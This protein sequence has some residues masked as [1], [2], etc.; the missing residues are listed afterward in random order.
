MS[1]LVER[2]WARRHPETQRV[3]PEG[4]PGPTRCSVRARV[5]RRIVWLE[6][7]FRVMRP[8]D[9]GLADRHSRAVRVCPAVRDHRAGRAGCSGSGPP[10]SSPSRACP[11]LEGCA[12]VVVVARA[13]RRQTVDGDREWHEAAARVCRAAGMPPLAV[14]VATPHE[15]WRLDDLAGP[16][17]RSASSRR[18]VPRSLSPGPERSRVE[19]DPRISGLG[20]TALPSR[21]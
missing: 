19:C 5:H 15:I 9:L 14:A 21:P 13:G 1:G 17:S 20:P 18:G 6:R 10:S 2:H 16:A 8:H 7:P 4:K 12:L 3:G 11:T